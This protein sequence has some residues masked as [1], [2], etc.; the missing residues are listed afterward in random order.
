MT[1][2]SIGAFI[3]AVSK[4][5]FAAATNVRSWRGHL[6]WIYERVVGADPR[7]KRR[8]SQRGTTALVNQEP[9]PQKRS[10]VSGAETSEHIPGRD[11]PDKTRTTRVVSTSDR[12]TVV[13]EVG[14]SRGSVTREQSGTSRDTTRRDAARHQELEDRWKKRVRARW[15]S[16]S[17]PLSRARASPR[18]CLR[19]QPNWMRRY[20]KVISERELRSDFV[21]Q[22]FLYVL[23]QQNGEQG[24]AIGRLRNMA[25][26]D[27][28]PT[29]L[30]RSRAR[31]FF[32]DE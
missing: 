17:R 8:R 21:P 9:Q 27:L 29:V 10:A 28:L 6:Q 24:I 2:W 22:G 25:V 16:P 14:W 30:P 31:L 7:G 4:T 32:M 26:R 12:P 3:A 15:A 1:A 19:K 11:D 18:D 13:S 20:A 23:A 5:R